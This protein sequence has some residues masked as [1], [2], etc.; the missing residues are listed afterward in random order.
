MTSASADD[1]INPDDR[2]V[3]I[4]TGYVLPTTLDTTNTVSVRFRFGRLTLEPVVD[5]S[6]DRSTIDAGGA[7]ST[8]N[9]VNI[10]FGS[11]LRYALTSGRGIEFVGLGGARFNFNSVDPE[12]DENSTNTTTFS[13]IWG[14]GLDYWVSSRWVIS[15]AAFNPFFELSRQTQQSIAADTTNSD[16][17]IGI[18]FNPTVVGMVHLFF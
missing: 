15:M 1:D 8:T 4:G 10:G 3:G 18:I 7:D 16:M 13:V 5:F 14:L 12:G 17:G 11:N 6:Y 2:K 9:T